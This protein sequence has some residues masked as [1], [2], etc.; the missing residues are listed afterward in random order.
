MSSSSDT[1]FETLDQRVSYGIA[2]NVGSNIARQGGVEIDLSAF[3]IGLQDG[4]SGAQPRISEDVLKAAFLEVQTKIE[5]E[6]AA[7]AAEGAQIGKMFLNENRARAGVVVTASG[8]QYEVLRAGSGA[9]PTPDQTVEVHYHGTLVDGTVFDSSV[10]RG[11]SISFPVGGVIPGWVEALQLMAVGA[12]W[13]LFIP[14]ELGYGNRS[15]GPIPAGSV[16]IFE[17]E[18][19]SIK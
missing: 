11:E 16:L 18:L 4:L 14:A 17:V 3:I 8:L 9:K 10:Q 15:Q 1:P 5:A 6:S 2:L 7:D 19:I 12:K 13:K